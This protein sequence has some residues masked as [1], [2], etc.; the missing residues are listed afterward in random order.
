MRCESSSSA[1]L[2]ARLGA[3]VGVDVDVVRC[4]VTTPG[5][6][7]VD[8]ET[9]VYLNTHLVFFHALGHICFVEGDD[10]AC[11]KDQHALQAYRCLRDLHR[12]ATPTRGYQDTAPIGV[13]ARDC[14][15]DQ[16]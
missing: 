8:A 11:V 13:V 9:E 2:D 16:A 15:L 7:A 6:G 1:A 10:P 4:Q 5:Y 12:R 14:R 3:V